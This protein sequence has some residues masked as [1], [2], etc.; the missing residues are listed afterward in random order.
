[1]PSSTSS[2]EFVR[3]IPALNWTATA[4]VTL[5]V[6]LGSMAAW[7]IYCRTVEW[8]RPSIRNSDGLWA[9][10]RD[11]ID[12]EDGGVAI[13]GSSRVLFD[14][15][16]ETWRELTGGLP[17]QLAL[18]G[19][20]PA[21]FL[22]HLAQ[23][24][25][26]KGVLVVGVTEFLFF[27]PV[28]DVDDRYKTLVAF[29]QRTPADRASQWLSMNL[30]EPFAAF[31]DPDFALFTILRRQPW[32]PE[33]AGL[34]PRL[35]AVRKLANMDRHR[36]YLMWDRVE[37]DPAF[38]KITRDIW[39]AFLSA[40]PPPIAPEAFMKHVQGVIAQARADVAAIRARGG[41]VV[42]VRSPSAGPF[43]E[44]E[45]AAFPREQFFDPLVTAADAAGVHFED[46]ADLQGFELPEWSHIA[47]GQTPA[48]TRALV[49]H[50]RAALASRGT[51]R[52]VVGE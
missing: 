52:R 42:F 4:A 50:V 28:P 49:P 2:S 47:A 12:R 17:I 9:M 37:R 26:F 45:H 3:P 40:P 20:N 8:L 34:P 46:L 48:Y 13:V 10:T 41:E 23:E 6:V 11:R 44:I 35:P 32:W 43:L 7:E 19:T 25:S 36:Q 30:F 1:M 15:N 16:L 21:P 22:T 31:Y 14:I 29:K 38:Q 24:S 5:A 33:R 18:E 51:P 27:S 39:L